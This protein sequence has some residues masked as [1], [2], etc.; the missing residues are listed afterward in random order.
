MKLSRILAAVPFVFVCGCAALSSFFNG[1]GVPAIVADASAVEACLSAADAAG[2]LP[3]FADIDAAVAACV[4]AGI[5]IDATVQVV[6]SDL[7]ADAGTKLAP[8]VVSH[9]KALPRKA[10]ASD[11]GKVG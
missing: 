8:L 7:A 2:K 10:K 1:G 3:G 5:D 6:E 11:A 4:G 9:I